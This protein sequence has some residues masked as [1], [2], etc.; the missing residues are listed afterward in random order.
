MGEPVIAGASQVSNRIASLNGSRSPLELMTEVSLGAIEDAGCDLRGCIDAVVVL[1]VP[2]WSPDDPAELLSKE[3]GINA[4]THLLSCNGGE[5][6][7]SVTNWA[8]QRIMAGD[9]RSVLI[10][11]ANAMRTLELSNRTGDVPGWVTQGSGSS[12][13]VLGSERDGHSPEEALVGLDRPVHAYPILESAFRHKLGRSISD[14][15]E[16]LGRFFAQF[17][18]VAAKNPHAWFPQAHSA[19]ELSTPTAS[20]RMIG[21]PYPKLMN[22][23]IATDQAAAVLLS[24]KSVLEDRGTDDDLSVNWWGGAADVE[25]AWCVSTRPEIAT[26][27]A[28]RSAHLRSME[29]AGVTVDDIAHFDFYSCFPIAVEVACDVLGIDPFDPRGLTVTGGLPYAG[30]PASAYTLHSLTTMAHLLREDRG[31]LGMVTG[32]GMYLS[33]HSSLFLSTERRPS[34]LPN[35]PAP[36]DIDAAE[37]RRYAP[38]AESATIASYTVVHD[39]SGEPEF[40]IGILEYGN[41]DRTAARFDGSTGELDELEVHDPIGV[42]ASVTLNS[43]GVPVFRPS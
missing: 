24:D 33:K 16:Y 12:I 14:H 18:E 23:V 15:Q 34:G 29:M 4:V 9:L 3:I 42:Q 10:V 13:P 36:S 6:G 5:V 41:G 31:R 11:G 25:R 21:F 32:N 2:W 22:A 40:S 19:E 39:R 30:G 38:R 43:S 1:P 27:P 20:N 37:G 35:E 8:A 26:S 28:M 17:T 7:V